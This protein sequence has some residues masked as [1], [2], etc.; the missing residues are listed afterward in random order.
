MD[1]TWTTPDGR[2]SGPRM[3][4][5][6]QRHVYC[7]PSKLP[8]LTIQ[9][10]L[11]L[12]QAMET[13]ARLAKAT[14]LA[15]RQAQLD[16]LTSS[17][18]LPASLADDVPA[19]FFSEFSEVN[20][21]FWALR[22]KLEEAHAA[23][24]WGEVDYYLDGQQHDSLAG[25]AKAL[26]ASGESKDVSPVVRYL[27]LLSMDEILVRWRPEGSALAHEVKALIAA[28][29]S[30]EAFDALPNKEKFLQWIKEKFSMPI[31]RLHQAAAEHEGE[32]NN[33]QA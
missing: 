3:L 2:C 31:R 4:L 15:A 14:E 24:Q 12:F 6:S 21:A 11:R 26:G 29:E 1:S 28:T 23:R 20:G 16:G 7:R 13:D 10:L 25:L 8:P 33:E 22:Q 17:E 5:V 32:R 9:E 30:S 27:T 19:S 18:F